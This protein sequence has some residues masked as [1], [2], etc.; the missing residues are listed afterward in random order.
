MIDINNQDHKISKTSRVRALRMYNDHKRTINR[1]VSLT[2]NHLFKYLSKFSWLNTS[3]EAWMRNPFLLS[4]LPFLISDREKPD[5]LYFKVWNFWRKRQ[6][7]IE[8]CL[9]KCSVPFRYNCDTRKIN[10]KHGQRRPIIAVH[11]TLHKQ[12]WA[13]SLTR[14]T[15]RMIEAG[16]THEC[17]AYFR[18][19]APER[20]DLTELHP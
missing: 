16:N 10:H 20:H 15:P 13:S 12:R 19:A 9:F 5:L 11:S 3:I 18:A 4:R 8:H 14:S 1:C 17:A 6:C 2:F 7:N